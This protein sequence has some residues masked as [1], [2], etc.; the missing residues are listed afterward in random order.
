MFTV[1]NCLFYF[2]QG[3]VPRSYLDFEQY[4]VARARYDFAAKTNV[5]ISFKRVRTKPTKFY[6]SC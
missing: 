1:V 3:L 5:E 4:G 2:F 6:K